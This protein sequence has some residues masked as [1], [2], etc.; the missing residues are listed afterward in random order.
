MYYSLISSMKKFSVDPDAQAFITAAAI[1]DNTQKSA[2]NSLVLSLK[3]YGIWSKMK[4]LYPFVGGTAS[5]HKFNLKDPRDLNPAFRLTFN[6]GWTHSSNGALPNGTNAYAD[7]YLIPNT[8]MSTGGDHLSYYSRTNSSNI[9]DYLIG[10]ESGAPYTYLGIVG[11][12][13]TNGRGFYT[14]SNPTATYYLARQDN[15]LRDTRGLFIGT[16]N[17]AN[18]YYILNNN[19]LATNTTLS[20]D[21]TRFTNKLYIAAFPANNVIVANGYTNKECAFAS[22]GNELTTLDASNFYTAVQA[23][24][25]SLSRQV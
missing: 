6:G 18:T 20:T 2:V 13:N 3:S 12:R 8:V 24:Q 9:V 22:I 23:Y 1:T 7:T 19:I 4:A 10:G 25:T 11:K 16:S 15:L 21:V 5:S 17:G 14:T